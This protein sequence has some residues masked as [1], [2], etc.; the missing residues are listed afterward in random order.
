ME[1]VISEIKSGRFVKKNPHKMEIR[2]IQS[3]PFD[4]LYDYRH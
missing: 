4:G 2:K 3:G 1:V